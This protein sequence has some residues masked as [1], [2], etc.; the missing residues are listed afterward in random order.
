MEIVTDAAR[1][2]GACRVNA[3]WLEI[4]ALSCVTADALRF[5]FDAVAQG[6]PA[7]GARLEII[8][9]PGEGVCE[10]CA[11]PSPMEALY[12]L[13]PH[14]EAPAMRPQRGTELR[15]KQIEVG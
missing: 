13:C 2:E 9:I 10:R 3:V 4:G 12:G 1:C 5:C 8:G 15:V 14:C 11:R 7:E 6:T